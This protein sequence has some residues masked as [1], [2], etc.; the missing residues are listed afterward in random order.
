MCQLSLFTLWR[1]V[2]SASKVFSRVLLCTLDSGLYMKHFFVSMRMILFEISRQLLKDGQHFA[3][4]SM[5]SA[6]SGDPQTF[7]LA[8]P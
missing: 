3:L 7:T 2:L 4:V 1:R 5:I 8:P 6:D